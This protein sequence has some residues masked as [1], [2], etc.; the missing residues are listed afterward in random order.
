LLH[1]FKNK[2]VFENII[3]QT[4]YLPCFNAGSKIKAQGF[5]RILPM[6]FFLCNAEINA[7]KI[8]KTVKGTVYDKQSKISLPGA[9]VYIP[10]TNPVK[11]TITD[12]NGSF[13]LENIETG[14]IQLC[15]VHRV[16][17]PVH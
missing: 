7:Q 14:C 6:A 13:R 8:V 12:E 2:I 9:T 10:G 4:M 5:I 17:T 1:P 16:R 15:L 11:G 3:H